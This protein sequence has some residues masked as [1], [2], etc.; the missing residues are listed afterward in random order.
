[1]P[2]ERMTA[3]P[4]KTCVPGVHAYAVAGVRATTATATSRISAARLATRS[5]RSILE[6]ETRALFFESLAQCL[7][8]VI[9]GAVDGVAR[10]VHVFGKPAA[11]LIAVRQAV[12]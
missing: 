2:A 8:L 7:E 9:D 3:S 12:P 1:M 6:M 4:R 5:G 10:R 11:Q